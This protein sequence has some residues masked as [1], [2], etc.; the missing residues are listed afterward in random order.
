MNHTYYFRLKTLA[1]LLVG[2]G[3]LVSTTACG[4]EPPAPLSTFADFCKKENKNK[5]VALEGFVKPTGLT[6]CKT[7]CMTGLFE[8]RMQ[9]GRGSA[10][11]DLRV[12]GRNGMEKLKKSYRR[13]DFTI[14]DKE[15]NP[16]KFGSPARLHGRVVY[17]DYD[18]SRKPTCF[19]KVDLI[20]K[21]TYKEKTPKATLVSPGD[22]CSGKY[23]DAYIAVK[24]T[25]SLPSSLY[26]R[27]GCTLKLSGAGGEA[28]PKFSLGTGANYMERLPRRYNPSM[29]KI[30]ST[31]GAIIDINRPVRL[32]GLVQS[33]ESGKEKVKK[34]NL[35]VERVIQ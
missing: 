11:V 20:E 3:L 8:R 33:W 15:G 30:R 18:K 5:R 29:L 6:F 19:I 9:E 12:R 25:L 13:A 7:S 21:S 17:S 10:R 31:Q 32:E 14:Y 26:C 24:G 35:L 23:D 4:N 28:S 22:Y 1:A 34:C 16:I 27:G 2:A